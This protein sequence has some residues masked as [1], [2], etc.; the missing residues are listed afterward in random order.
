VTCY[1]CVVDAYV[2][3]IHGTQLREKARRVLLVAKVDRKVTGGRA[4]TIFE[5]VGR[6]RGRHQE[7]AAPVGHVLSDLLADAARRTGDQDGLSGK[8]KG[9]R[10]LAW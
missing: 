4:E 3:T 6:L 8:V 10:D 7:R 2:D 5:L 1:A 9:H